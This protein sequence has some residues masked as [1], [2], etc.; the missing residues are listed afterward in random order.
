M[1]QQEAAKALPGYD[2]VYLGDTLHVPYGGRSPEA[3]YHY[4]TQ[5]VQTLF[6][7][8]CALVIVACNTA[9]AQALRP[10]QQNWL[11][12]QNDPSR[13][14]LGV[15]VPTLEAAIEADIK[16]IGLIATEATIRSGVYPCELSKLNPD[17]QITSKACPLLVPMIEHGGRK[18][19][20]PILDEYLAPMVDAGIES[21]ILG[22][23]H[24]PVLK[25]ELEE[26]L[27]G[28]GISLISQD[29]IIPEK[30]KEYLSRHPEMAARLTQNGKQDYYVSDLTPSY[31]QA[32][33]AICGQ[34]IPLEK[35][36]L[37]HIGV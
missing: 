5:A 8:D 14:V 22:C 13:R 26:A 31:E 21:L 1:I 10:L 17:L 19:V 3:I 25:A 37:S 30:L 33:K 18:W 32:A 16:H 29:A 27:D 11:P 24:Y 23:T 28:T 34:N 36:L 2:M 6:D 7:H 9:S 4:T 20:K 35:I 15:I 12:A